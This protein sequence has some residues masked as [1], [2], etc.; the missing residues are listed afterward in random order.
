VVSSTV[1]ALVDRDEARRLAEQ[2]LSRQ[3]YRRDDP[4]PLERASEWLTELLDSLFSGSEGFAPAAW[5]GVILLVLVAAAVVV[6][7]LRRTGG[8]RGSAQR[9][10]P[11]DPARAMTAAEHRAAADA[12]AARGDFDIAIRERMRA[13]ARELEARGVLDPRPGRTAD[14]LSVEAGA[15]IP[16]LAD[17]LRAASRVFDDVWYGAR[18]AT[19]QGY[20][21]VQRADDA[22]RDA[23]LAATIGPGA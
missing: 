19:A 3:E 12:A 16:A 22:V 8:I 7:I 14:E 11:L 1:L 9:R 6:V 17:D 10:D 2:E 15:V 5:I 18:P 20:A 21:V 4:T 13:S 23:R